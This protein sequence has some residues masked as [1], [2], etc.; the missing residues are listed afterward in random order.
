MRFSANSAA[1]MVAPV[2]PGLASASECPAAT[3]AA[4]ITIEASGRERTA[5]TGSS[6]LEIASVAGITSTPSIESRS[7]RSCG[8]PNTRTP[9]PSDATAL[10][11]SITTEGPASAPSASKATVT[12]GPDR[13]EDEAPGGRAAWASTYSPSERP[14][15]SG[16]VS[17]L[18]TTSRPA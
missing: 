16:G 12:R 2:D 5:R 8:S 7:E 15:S 6:S 3:S 9:I 4:A 10:I 11:P 1:V 17:S 18:E 13:E 14:A